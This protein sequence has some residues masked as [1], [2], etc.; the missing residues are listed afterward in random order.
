MASNDKKV[1]LR[2]LKLANFTK[3]HVEAAGTNQ[4]RLIQNFLQLRFTKRKGSKI[5]QRF[6]AMEK[7]FDRCFV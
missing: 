2:G 7:F 6:L 3:R 4:G 1:I 5:C